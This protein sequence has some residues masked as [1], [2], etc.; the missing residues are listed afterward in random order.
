ML[1]WRPP[2]FR[3]PRQLPRPRPFSGSGLLHCGSLLESSRRYS[4]SQN[5]LAGSF[6]ELFNY[7]TRGIYIAMGVKF[8]IHTKDISK[9]LWGTKHAGETTSFEYSPPPLSRTAE[10]RHKRHLSALL[11]QK[12]YERFT[13]SPRL[14]ISKDFGPRWR[15]W[16]RW[17]YLPRGLRLPYP[18]TPDT[19]NL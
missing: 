10:S 3:S 19:I 7:R 18:H 13:S 4:Y 1:S 9:R 6:L 11:W 2:T 8:D 17:R 16:P 14:S 15:Y 5:L 12:R